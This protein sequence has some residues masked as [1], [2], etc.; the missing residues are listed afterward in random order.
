M[1][2]Q[3]DVQREQS[4]L[5]A[6]L[7][8][9]GVGLYFRGEMPV[10]L[11]PRL[12]GL[13]RYRELARNCELVLDAIERVL[14]LYVAEPEIQAWF[15][16][17]EKFRF[18]STMRPPYERWVHLAR[19]DLAE[20]P[21]GRF[22]IM[23][24]N[25]DCPGAILMQTMFKPAY[26]EL[27][28]Y[29]AGIA[30]LGPVPQ[31]ADDRYFFL[32]SMVDVEQG[33]RG[34]ERTPTI[35]FASSTYRTILSD[36]DLLERAAGELGLSARAMPV[37]NLMTVNGRPAWNDLPIDLVWQKFDAFID[38]SGQY[39][40]C[41]YETSPTE[42]DVY[43][44][45]LL[46]Q[47]FV[48][49]NSFVSAMVA[50]SKRILHVLMLPEIQ[51]LLTESQRAATKELCPQT[52]PLQVRPVGDFPSA[53]EVIAHKD[54]YVLKRVIDTRGRGVSLGCEQTAEAWQT[55]VNESIGGP[56]VAQRYIEHPAQRMLVA[57]DEPI[58]ERMFANVAMFMI[59]GRAAGLLGR[60]SPD[61]RTNVAR[62]GVFQ[63]VYVV[64]R[65]EPIELS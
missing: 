57:E 19:L 22:Q 26:E 29:R 48:Y 44:R 14:R 27:E 24:T 43:W 53:R 64:E 18:L 63:P 49:F 8:R 65:P 3:L 39:R 2:L 12:I 4:Q 61:R 20:T 46:D 6:G 34:R 23:E 25:C 31:P 62:S 11:T 51:A 28:V 7:R 5:R 52:F 47:R 35:L 58:R 55:Q 33:I 32:R 41:I 9:D 16:E 1:Q 36:L 50:E 15:P 60:A 37:Q 42:C 56:V 13:D 59:G 17:L 21:D 38:E 54:E 10:S 45:A 40:P 30:S